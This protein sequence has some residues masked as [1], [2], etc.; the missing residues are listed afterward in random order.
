L[1]RHR[2]VQSA[3]KRLLIEKLKE[4]EERHKAIADE[5]QKQRTLHQKNLYRTLNGFF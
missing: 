1:K 2:R 4:K 3:Y 5:K